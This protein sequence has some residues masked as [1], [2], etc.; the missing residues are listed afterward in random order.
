MVSTS[1]ILSELVP[2]LS[3][4]LRTARRQILEFIVQLR[5]M[6][7][8]EIVHITPELHDR[9]F[10]LLQERLDKQ[11]SW[12]DAASFEV[13]QERHIQQALTT[14]RHFEQAGFEALLRREP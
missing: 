2:L 3:S 5:A 8:V 9:A 4:R 6:P 1:D 14:D 7:S 13:M 11:W 12:V 10:A